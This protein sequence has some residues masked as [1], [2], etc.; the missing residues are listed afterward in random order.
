MASEI[1]VPEDIE[2]EQMLL[3]GIMT[4]ARLGSY[5]VAAAILRPADFYLRGH[6]LVFKACGELAG[7][8][9]APDFIAVRREL[10]KRNELNLA[11]G[12]TCILDIS[13]AFGLGLNNVEGH[14]RKVL[15]YSRRRQVILACL[16]TIDKAGNPEYSVESLLHS[17]QQLEGYV[18]QLAAKHGCQ[19]VTVDQA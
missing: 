1:Q 17:L 9:I 16:K 13:R 4:N 5:E 14:A 7:Q 6:E 18:R 12:N 11:G 2:L 3:G 19:V 15:E 8:G 10:D